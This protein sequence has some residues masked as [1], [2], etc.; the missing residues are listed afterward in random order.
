[1]MAI[2]EVTE[3]ATE[4]PMMPPVAFKMNQE[5]T[6][7]NSELLRDYNFACQP[8]KD[9]CWVTDLNSGH[10]GSSKRS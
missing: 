9:H 3:E 8:T 1:M 10:L 6:C 7:H 4:A 2:L 5:T